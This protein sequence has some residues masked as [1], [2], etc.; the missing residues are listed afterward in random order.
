[1]GWNPASR[2]S[3]DYRHEVERGRRHYCNAKSTPAGLVSKGTGHGALPRRGRRHSLALEYGRPRWSLPAPVHSGP[4]YQRLVL[5]S[6]PAMATW[7]GRTRHQ[8]RSIGAICS[9]Q[10]SFLYSPSHESRL[11]ECIGSTCAQDAM[12]IIRVYGLS[13][14]SNAAHPFGVDQCW[15]PSVRCVRQADPG[16]AP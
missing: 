6:S 12:R 9:C 10:S 3:P 8:Q 5:R 1:M 4:A 16:T 2:R 11:A 7:S 14:R 13:R 15:T